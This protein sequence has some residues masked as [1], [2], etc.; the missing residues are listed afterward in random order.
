[1]GAVFLEPHFRRLLLASVASALTAAVAYSF[2]GSTNGLGLA[3]RTGIAT[4]TGLVTFLFFFRHALRKSDF[5]ALVRG[6]V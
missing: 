6:K 3:V 2:M 1:M 5:R 4:A